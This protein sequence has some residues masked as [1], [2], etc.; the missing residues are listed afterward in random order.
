M[1]FLTKFTIFCMVNTNIVVVPLCHVIWCVIQVFTV[2]LILIIKHKQ[3]QLVYV[4]IKVLNDI[5]MLP[6]FD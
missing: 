3:C 2:V 5:D 6:I 4:G 1:C